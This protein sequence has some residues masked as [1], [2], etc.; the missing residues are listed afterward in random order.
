[1]SY[2]IVWGTTRFLF[3][4]IIVSYAQCISDLAA[5]SNTV[6]PVLFTDDTIFISNQHLSVFTNDINNGVFAYS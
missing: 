4:T 2:D 1:M 5:V 3:R 6:C